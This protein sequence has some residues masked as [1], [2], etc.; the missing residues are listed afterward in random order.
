[1]Q[2]CWRRCRAAGVHL[3]WCLLHM[4][5]IPVWDE[6]GLCGLDLGSSRWMV[7]LMLE[8]VVQVTLAGAH[9][10][11]CESAYSERPVLCKLSCHKLNQPAAL[12]EPAMHCA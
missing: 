12:Q 6:C 2:T 11:L 10:C 3:C 7:A 8:S 5:Q 4:W 1:M 9:M